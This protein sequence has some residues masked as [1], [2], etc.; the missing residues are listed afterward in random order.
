MSTTLRELLDEGHRQLKSAGITNPQLAAEVMLRSLLNLRRVDLYLKDTMIVTDEIAQSFGEMIE[1]KLRR[2]PLQYIVGE[3][4]WFGLS[5][6]CTPAALVPRPETEVI[7]ERALEVIKDVPE[8]LIADIGTGSGCIAIAMAK[9]RADAR[10]VA[11]DISEAALALARENVTRHCVDSR[12]AL[13]H[14]SLFT[15]LTRDAHFDLIVSN[16]PYISE[17]A[18]PRLMTEV[19]DHE[20]REAL[21]AG[22]DGL[23]II[24][25]LVGEAH[26][27]LGTSGFLVFEMSEEQRMPLKKLV[28]QNGLWNI[29]RFIEDYNHRDRGVILSKRQPS[30]G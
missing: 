29:V 15:P 21:V 8:P 16:P 7:V 23:D 6:R 20:P 2:E 28:L 30:G 13:R 14:G 12:V 19:R 25:A 22:M 10:I 17:T 11:T 27:Y 18:Y 4:E 9:S 24:R 5:I 26:H 1:R 3:T